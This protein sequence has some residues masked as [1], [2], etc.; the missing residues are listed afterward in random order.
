[1]IADVSSNIKFHPLVAELYSRGQKLNTSL[2]FITQSNFPGPKDVR[3]N[4]IHFFM[5]KILK[6]IEVQ[7]IDIN[8]LSDIDSKDFM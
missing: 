5:I 1:M 6:K 4:T 3:L 2:V 8:H 7:Q